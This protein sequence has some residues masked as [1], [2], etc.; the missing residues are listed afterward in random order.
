MEQ[1]LTLNSAA[2]QYSIV[3][4]LY[5]E[6][7]IWVY[8]RSLNK[9]GFFSKNDINIKYLTKSTLKRKL[10]TNIFFSVVGDKIILTSIKKMPF[11]TNKHKYKVNLNEARLYANKTANHSMRLIKG[12]NNTTIKYFLISIYSS[13]Y[14]DKKPYAL[15]LIESDIKQSCS[16][17]KRALKIFGVIKHKKFQVKESHRSYY[18]VDKKLINL[19]PNYYKM[20][21][22]ENITR[23]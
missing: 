2:I 18:D 11:N 22:G 5:V 23:Q 16:T 1:T 15:E 17:I 19:T 13:R 7:F 6:Y 3:N 8:L 10:N 4:N 9:S 21:I 20:P 14:E 12:W